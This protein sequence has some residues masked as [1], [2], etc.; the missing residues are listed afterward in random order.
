MNYN[1][2]V[3]ILL[4]VRDDSVQIVLIGLYEVYGSNSMQLLSVVFDVE[5]EGDVALS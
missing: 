2:A 1:R 5:V 4:K 3:K